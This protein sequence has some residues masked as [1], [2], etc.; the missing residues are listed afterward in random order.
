MAAPEAWLSGPVAG[1]AP[2]LQPA[3]HALLQAAAE[4]RTAAAPLTTSELWVSPGGAASAGYHLRHVAGSLDRLLT[5]ARG[6]SLDGPQ[7][8]ALVTEALPGDPPADAATLIAGVERAVGHA[9]EVLRRTP[10][11]TL[12]EARTVGRG[13]LPST[14]L[15]LLFHAAEHA[16]R[17]AGQ[18]VTTA[19]IVRGLGLGSA[20]RGEG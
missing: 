10:V 4:I 5:Y 12:G 15:G 16:Q 7:R 2:E 20:G 11:E 14:V 8:A 1:V 18:L 6:Q 13:K 9:L 3:A 19:K 17:H